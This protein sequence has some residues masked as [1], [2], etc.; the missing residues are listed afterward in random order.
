MKQIPIEEHSTKHLTNTPENCQEKSKKLS[1]FR[2]SYWD[3][4]GGILGQ[5]KKKGKSKEIRIKRTLVNNNVIK[6]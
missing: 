2:E 3:M 5:K 1:Q 4:L 6:D